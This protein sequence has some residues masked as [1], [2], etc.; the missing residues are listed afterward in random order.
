[1]VGAERMERMVGSSSQQVPIDAILAK[2]LGVDALDLGA[3]HRFAELW[4]ASDEARMEVG[5]LV[6]TASN[7]VKAPH[8]ELPLEALVLGLVKVFW[9]DVVI[10]LFSLVD[11]EAVLGGNPR[12]NI[13]ETLGVGIVQDAVELPR[14]RDSGSRLL[15][16]RLSR[17]ALSLALLLGKTMIASIESLLRVVA[18]LP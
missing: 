9:H 14:K 7:A 6:G 13:V 3:L 10:E 18:G 4:L 17:C 5:S 1:M 16:E 11:L 15:F 8:V 12:N 2:L